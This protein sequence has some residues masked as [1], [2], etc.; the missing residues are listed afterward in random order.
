MSDDY[1]EKLHGALGAALVRATTRPD[2][3]FDV[4]PEAI[5]AVML[6]LAIAALRED[7]D[8]PAALHWMRDRIAEVIADELPATQGKTTP[9]PL[10]EGEGQPRSQAAHALS[11]Q[12]MELLIPHPGIVQGGAL[13]NATATWLATH[14]SARREGALKFFWDLVTRMVTATDQEKARERGGG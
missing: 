2:G 12:V 4:R 11:L 6:A 13:A 9:P 14:E 3:S 8:V 5:A 10:P 1:G 7:R